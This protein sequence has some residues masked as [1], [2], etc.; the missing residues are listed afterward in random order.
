MEAARATAR[1]RAHIINAFNAVE[2]DDEEK[3]HQALARGVDV[4]L[5][6]D[7]RAED[8]EFTLLTYAAYNGCERTCK[9]LLA[10]GADPNRIDGGGD[11]PLD[12]ACYRNGAGGS[13][14]KTLSEIIACVRCLLEANADVN[15]SKQ[16]GATVLHMAVETLAVKT[17]AEDH[18]GNHLGLIQLLLSHG[19][20]IE[21]KKG[22]GHTPL[23]R[24]LFYGLKPTVLFL[25]RAGACVKVLKHDEVRDS[26]RDLQENMDL[27][28]YLIDVINDGGWA[29][30]A[31]RHRDRCL[32]VVSRCNRRLP[33]DVAL[34][35]VSFWSLPH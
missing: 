11:A 24:A 29:A 9:A 12:L 10:L 6:S 4:N 7:R 13:G 16:S 17:L 8:D 5:S 28:D 27:N 31:R 14:A 22:R 18:V 1:H 30:R 15:R 2:E 35:V 32:G 20:N 21:A 19:A 25:L 33:R 3:L 34:S 26:N 23:A